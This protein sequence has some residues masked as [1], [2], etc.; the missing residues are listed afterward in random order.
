MRLIHG[1]GRNVK[2]APPDLNLGLS[3]FRCCFG[4]V[5]PGKAA[6]V[7][8]VEAPGSVNG[9]PHLVNAVQNKPKGADGPLQ[10]GGV[11]NVKFIASI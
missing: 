5:Q 7:A 1:W 2:R 11:A 4:L 10:N 8:L 3:M 9:Q 6:I